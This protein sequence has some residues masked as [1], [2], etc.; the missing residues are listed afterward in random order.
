[1][2]LKGV[3]LL[4]D[5]GLVHKTSNAQAAFR[6][7][8]FENLSHHPYSPDLTPSDCYLSRSLKSHLSGHLFK[9]KEFT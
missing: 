5:N 7:C 2:L 4:H 9:D 6:A 1:M 8:G 3:I